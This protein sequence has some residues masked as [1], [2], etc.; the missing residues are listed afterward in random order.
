M[1]I[2]IKLDFQLQCR[3]KCSKVYFVS[4]TQG[5]VENPVEQLN[6]SSMNFL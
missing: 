5:V 3:N 2:S 6:S 1:N 4:L